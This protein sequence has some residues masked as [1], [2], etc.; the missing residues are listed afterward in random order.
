MKWL[1]TILAVFIVG[2]DSWESLE[3]K[4]ERNQTEVERLLNNAKKTKSEVE[5]SKKQLTE[6][7][8]KCDEI[9]GKLDILL[10]HPNPKPNP[11]PSPISPTPTP[12][13]LPPIPNPAPLPP[14]EPEDGKFAIAKAVYNIAKVINSPDRVLESKALAAV[15]E[16]VAAQVAAGALDGS[17]LDPQWHKISVA[18]TAGN[19]PIMSKHL[20]AWKDAAEQL[21]DAIAERFENNKLK[22]N[23]NWS[24][25]LNEIASGLKAVR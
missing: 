14:D 11:N 16:S 8:T 9:I 17:L 10:N 21:S 22:T 20:S 25:L 6:Q 2:C 13:P 18:L 24:D 1:I 15:F 5:K 19:K 23:Q 12:S 4:S 3:S 7:L